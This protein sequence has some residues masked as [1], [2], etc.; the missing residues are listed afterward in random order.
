MKAFLRIVLLSILFVI[1]SCSKED[2]DEVIIN[3]GELILLDQQFNLDENVPS[4]TSVGVVRATNV[5][6]A[7][8]LIYKI[9]TPETPF[10][11][12]SE[13]G[14]L[15]VASTAVID[16]E[17]TSVYVFDIEV[18]NGSTTTKGE[19]TVRINDLPDSTRSA[20][21]KARLLAYFK[22]LVLREE[23]QPA[24][25]NNTKWSTTM[26]IFITGNFTAKD[27]REIAEFL[28]FIN[29]LFTDGFSM[30]LVNSIVEANTEIYFESIKNL[31]ENRPDFVGPVS[32]INSGKARI[33]FQGNGEIRSSSIWINT[34]PNNRLATIKHEFLHA[35]GLGHSNNRNSIMYPVGGANSSLL[36]DDIFVI[37][38]LYHPLMKVGANVNEIDTA[39]NQIL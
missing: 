7:N 18:T 34:A 33:S 29:P 37:R 6:N 38:A 24:S 5:L 16:F 10:V 11:I 28:D 22:Y 9:I 19:I 12:N 13:T 14:E 23:S 4:Q 39:L 25:E 27:E 15:L 31:E 36:E 20:E 17:E 35:I 32:S 1:A 26:T 2:D 21:E 30:K 3:N 8:T